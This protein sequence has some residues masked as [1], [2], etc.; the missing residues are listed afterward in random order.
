MHA[1]YI[2]KLEILHG[3]F[4]KQAEKTEKAHFSV[5][6]DSPSAHVPYKLKIKAVCERGV[7]MVRRRMGK[8]RAFGRRLPP[9]RRPNEGGK[10]RL[11]VK[12]RV[13]AFFCLLFGLLIMMDRN[14]RP[15]I[16]AYGETAAKQVATRAV[17]DGVEKALA[18][19]A[20]SY[21]QLVTVDRDEKGTITS[22]EA[23]VV[24]INRLKAEATNAVME[25]LE[26]YKKQTVE[27]PSG[28]LIGGD[29]FTGRGPYIPIKISMSGTA[30]SAMNSRFTSAGVNQ[31]SHQIELEV[32]VRIYA[33]IP[34]FRSSIETTT[35]YLIAETVLVGEVPDSFT[36]VDGDQ[37]DMVRKI[38][39]YADVK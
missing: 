29:F 10:G 17:N 18:A 8:R 11:S 36:Q 21:D 5:W 1:Q 24:Q 31:T 26:K 6:R 39:D 13:L 9:V 32:T 22:I 35:N 4:L 33:A 38:F 34:G 15:L 25:E 20:I 7:A 12:L 2:R 19:S 28:N 3:F 30:L 23:D 16:Q 14:L 27:I 37:A